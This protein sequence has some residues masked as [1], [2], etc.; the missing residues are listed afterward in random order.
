MCFVKFGCQNC[1]W[2]FSNIL[3]RAIHRLFQ[4]PLL[5]YLRIRIA[6]EGHVQ[7]II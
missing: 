3:T 5:I 2:Y 4:T 1:M 7:L 6:L